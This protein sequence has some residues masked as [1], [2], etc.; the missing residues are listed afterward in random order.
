MQ[1]VVRLHFK[2][3][4]PV[5]RFK[6]HCSK[7]THHISIFPVSHWSEMRLSSCH[8]A[9]I[10]SQGEITS[11]SS[12]EFLLAQ[13]PIDW[14]NIHFSTYTLRSALWCKVFSLGSFKSVHCINISAHLSTICIL[15]VKHTFFFAGVKCEVCVCGGYSAVKPYMLCI[16]LP[17]GL[18]W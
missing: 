11:S 13:N 9:L 5:C 14:E 18:K 3:L 6:L 16:S 17:F 12:L 1:P 10:T 7:C 8:C 4:N 15:M 2:V